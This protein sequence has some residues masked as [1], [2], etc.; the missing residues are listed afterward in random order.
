MW[1]VD[2]TLITRAAGAAVEPVVQQAGQQ[3]V[4]EVVHLELRL[5]AVFGDRALAAP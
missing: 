2:E 3:E 4:A 1:P 5:V